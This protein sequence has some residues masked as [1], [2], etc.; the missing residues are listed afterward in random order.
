MT[1]SAGER[2]WT[3]DALLTFSY[4]KVGWTDGRLGT[5]ATR[6][7]QR[8]EE[9]KETERQTRSATT[10][11]RRKTR[12]DGIHEKRNE[13]KIRTTRKDQDQNTH[14]VDRPWQQQQ[15]LLC[16]AGVSALETKRQP[17]EKDQESSAC[18]HTRTRKPVTSHDNNDKRGQHQQQHWQR[19]QQ[20]QQQHQS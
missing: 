14:A 20:H 17:N 18:T 15:Q 6:R 9:Q 13:S 16:S 19:R 10:T 11:T 4:P 5:E 12:R 3:F 8:G 2:S 7:S 1:T